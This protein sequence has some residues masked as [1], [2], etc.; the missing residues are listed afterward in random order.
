MVEEVL[1]DCIIVGNITTAS[2][3]KLERVLLLQTESFKGLYIRW[4]LILSARQATGSLLSYRQL[5]K[6]IADS[7]L[8]A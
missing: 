6:I 4:N 2:L 7:M 5:S 3:D 8:L 1:K